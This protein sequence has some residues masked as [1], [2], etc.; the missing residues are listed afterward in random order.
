MTDWTRE[1]ELILYRNVAGKGRDPFRAHLNP[2]GSLSEAIEVLTT[3]ASEFTGKVSPDGSLLAYVSDTSG[4]F[5]VFVCSYPECDAQ[6]KVSPN[7]GT[8][9]KWARDGSELYYVEDDTLMASPVSRG[10]VG[11]P[12]RLF[13]DARLRQR[14]TAVW[15]YDVAADGRFLTVRPADGEEETPDSIRVIENWYERFR[16]RVQD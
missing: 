5:E 6:R 4:R 1:N 12:A 3:P 9:V 14:V 7:G 11:E 10:V 8:Q 15:E 16:D 2:D 13:S